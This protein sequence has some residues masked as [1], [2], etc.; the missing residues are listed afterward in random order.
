MPVL[1][2]SSESVLFPPLM[3]RASTNAYPALSIQAECTILEQIAPSAYRA[4]LPNG[5]ITVA[6]LQR[7]EA[8]TLGRLLPGEKVSVVVNPA[9]FDRARVFRRV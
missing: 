6:F 2:S 8:E 3:T 1:N 5:K 7:K 9:D 4:T